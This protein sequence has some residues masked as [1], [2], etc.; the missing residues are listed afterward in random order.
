MFLY[1]YCFVLFILLPY[2]FGDNSYESTLESES[3]IIT[4]ISVFNTDSYF[5]TLIHIT[6][7]F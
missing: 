4:V 3:V 2:K 7:N 6:K 5:K 1:Y